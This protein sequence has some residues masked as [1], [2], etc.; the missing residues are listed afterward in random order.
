MVLDLS[1]DEVAALA[2][3]HT[4]TFGCGTASML[5]RIGRAGSCR[6]IIR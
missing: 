3:Y 5:P 2:E 4:A 6:R 1:D